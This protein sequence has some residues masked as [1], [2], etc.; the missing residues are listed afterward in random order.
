MSSLISC[1]LLTLAPGAAFAYIDPN[2]GGILFQI[3]TPVFVAIV[4][5]WT[6]LKHKLKALWTRV[7][8]AFRKS[9]R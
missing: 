9:E 8:S 2:A 5:F 6:F 7:V 3:L 1:V 4:V